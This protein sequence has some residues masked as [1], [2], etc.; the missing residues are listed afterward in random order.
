MSTI[1]IADDELTTVKNIF[2]SIIKKENDVKLIGITS[3][4]K[5]VLEIMQKNM[6]D[7]LLL[8]LMMPVMDGLELL[9][10]LIDQKDKY[11]TNTKIIVISSYIDKL[12]KTT[13]YRKYIYGILPKPYDTSELLNL[14]K[15]INIENNNRNVK[16]YIEE[17]LNQFNFNKNSHSYKYLKDA[18]YLIIYEG[19]INFE[20]ENDIYIKV[21]KINNKSNGLLIKWAIEKLMNNMYM[22]TKY[23]VIKNYFNFI[24]EK[25]PTTKLFI[26]YVVNN[27]EKQKNN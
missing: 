12:Y 17:T 1:L 27:F 15:K 11:L 18:I 2:N 26:R 14:I 7:I 13:K 6:P 25:K 20:L 19:K 8:D 16:K 24:E 4:G 10:I 22:D 3:N 21:A 23:N 5:E 9:D